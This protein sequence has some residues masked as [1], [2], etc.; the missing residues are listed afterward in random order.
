MWG[1]DTIVDVNRRAGD[2]ARA[3][4][5]EPLKITSDSAPYFD[6]LPFLS[7]EENNV[8]ARL[9]RIDTLFVDVSGIGRDGEPAMSLSELRERLQGLVKAH[10]TIHVGIVERGQFQ[11]YLGVWV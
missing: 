8:D 1:L 4:G 3:E 11:A 9:K 5:E 6:D 10:E 7:D 2:K